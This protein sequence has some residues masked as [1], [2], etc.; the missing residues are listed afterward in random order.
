MWHD[1]AR[2]RIFK[3]VSC[4]RTRFQGKSEVRL[5][6]TTYLENS[7]IQP[8]EMMYSL[9]IKEFGVLLST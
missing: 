9:C 2:L 1:V 5:G 6:G 7:R 4:I 8:L 3:N